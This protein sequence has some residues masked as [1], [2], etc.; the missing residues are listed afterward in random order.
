[1]AISDPYV[2]FNFLVEIDGIIRGAFH[3][4]S[5]IGSKIDVIEHREGG[6][7]ITTR[8]YPGRVSCPNIILKW[9]MA[10]DRDLYDWYQ[11]WAKGDPAAPRKNG[12]IV[13]LDRQGQEK[14]RWNFFNTW[15]A[16]WDGPTFNAES[17]DIAILTLELTQ[18]RPP[19]R[20]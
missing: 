3:E 10:D 6:E 11:Q 15:P 9:G 17:N 12:S 4:V 20:A 13:I 7:N 5:G 14:E 19:E 1:M 2:N 8:K 18:E 16:A